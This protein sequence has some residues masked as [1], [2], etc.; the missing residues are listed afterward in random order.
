MNKKVRSSTQ[1]SKSKEKFIEV[2]AVP[3]SGKTYTLIQ[4]ALHLLF[5]GVPSNEILVLSFSNASVAEIRSRMDRTSRHSAKDAL[6]QRRP[7]TG[8]TNLSD[9]EVQTAHAFAFGFAKEKQLVNEKDSRKLLAEAIL[10][11]KRDGRKRILWPDLSSDIRQRRFEQLDDLSEVQKSPD[12]LRLFDVA[13]AS[14]QTVREVISM[15]QFSDF[16]PYV[17]VL[18]EIL[19]RYAA[20]KRNRGVIDFGDMLF[21]AT[22][23]IRR[24]APTPYTHILV[25]EYQ[26]CSPAQVHLLAE[27]ASLDGRSIMVLGDCD[28]AIYG[29]GGGHYTPLSGVLEGVTEI[30][31]PC[32]QRLHAQNAALASA[33]AQHAPDQIIKAKR[34]GE[35]PVLVCTDTETAQIS[36]V[37]QDIKKRIDGGVQPEQIMVLARKQALLTPI[38]QELLALGVLTERNGLQRHRKHAQ[39]VLHMIHVIERC[40]ERETKITPAMLKNAFKWSGEIEDRRWDEE[41]KKLRKVLR[42]PSLEGRYRLC[43]KAYVRLHGGVRQNRQLRADVN[44][45]EPICRAH[46]SARSMRDAVRAM[47]KRAVLTGTIHSAKGGEWDDVFVVGVTDGHLPEYRSRDERSLSEERRLLY[48]AVTRARNGVRLYHSPA[49]DARS[50]QRFD[51]PSRFLDQRVLKTLRVE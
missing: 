44:R 38:E 13:R 49:N 15:S 17:H 9:I 19:R 1:I 14:G 16:A 41:S 36:R 28:Q 37:A 6:G 25:D 18:P 40:E 26:D 32:S 8:D 33:I 35:I 34:D 3:G 24:G 21:L 46:S 47:D 50:R 12:V 23:A 31:L 2:R 4:R 10:S 22:R 7:D 39:R 48:V 5:T 11:V 43:A 51:N 27:L 20:I 30:S 29:F 45:W 42:A